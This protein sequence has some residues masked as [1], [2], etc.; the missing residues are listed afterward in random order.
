[1]N[2]VTGFSAD[3]TTLDC[4]GQELRAGDTVAFASR[5]GNSAV[6]EIREV[7]GTVDKEWAKLVNPKHG[8]AGPKA[9]ARN[10]CKLEAKDNE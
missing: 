3:S 6:L 7:H 2:K 9:K 4:R 10:M 1:M 8:G 5:W